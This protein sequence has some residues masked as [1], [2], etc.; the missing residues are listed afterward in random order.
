MKA[1]KSS[2]PEKL[3]AEV[4]VIGGGGGGMAAAVAA[5]ENGAEVLLLE[6][7]RVPGGNTAMAE[8][9]F[10]AESDLQ[11]R[12]NIDA[13]VEGLFRTAMDFAHWTLDPR[14]VRVFLEKSADTVSWLEAKGVVFDGVFP[15]YPNQPIPTW[16][17]VRGRGVTLIRALIRSY[18]ALGG[19][20]LKQCRARQLRT[21]NKGR[22]TGVIAESGGREITI[23][24]GSVVIA[25]GG[26]G[27]NTAL[28]QQ[29]YPGY[30]E[31]M[32][33]DGAPNMG[34]G[35]EMAIA[36]G[37]ATEGLGILHMFGPRVPR[38]PYLS[39]LAGEPQTLW[40]NKRGE[41]FADETV[42]YRFPISANAVCRQP[43]KVSFT[44]LDEEMVRKIIT[45]G[46]TKGLSLMALRAKLP[47]L[48]EK[49]QQAADKGQVKIAGSWDGI[50]RWVGAEPR[51]LEATVNEYNSLCECGYDTVFGKDRRYLVPLRTPPYYAVRGGIVFHNTIGGIKINREMAVLNRQGESI[52]GLYAAGV[53][54]GGWEAETYCQELAGSAFG[55]AVNSGRI[56]GENAA[57]YITARRG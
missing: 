1:S 3:A 2:T 33:M 51:A 56:A 35:L 10:A 46:L 34:E 27:G 55:F 38:A 17:L 37:A 16:H 57:A 7:Q 23:A 28:V 29:Y 31:T 42:S 25:A 6:K 39:A 45:E 20:M 32:V 19:R 50:A 48:P 21:D 22:V 11:K 47:D 43:D 26:Y 41:R 36:A 12:L 49:L 14:V 4:V 30:T 13:R 18:E 15:N 9:L 53:D 5:A 52:P 54:T 44:L 24:A 40:V 8:G